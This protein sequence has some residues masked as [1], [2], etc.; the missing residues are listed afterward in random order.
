M[1]TITANGPMSPAVKKL[2]KTIEG[3]RELF[4]AAIG[5]PSTIRLKDSAVREAR[6]RNNPTPLIT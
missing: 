5:Q 4:R 2:M 6:Y 1:K 3:R